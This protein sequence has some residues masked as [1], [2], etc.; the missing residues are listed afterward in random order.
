MTVKKIEAQK[1][2]EMNKLNA[3][4]DTAKNIRELLDGARKQYGPQDWDDED[5]ESQVLELV[6]EE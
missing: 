2:I 6:N 1:E 5:I 3:K 4:Y